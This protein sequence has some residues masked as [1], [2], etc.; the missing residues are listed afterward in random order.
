M[1]NRLALIDEPARVMTSGRPAP[2]NSQG[3]EL[4]RAIEPRAQV[5][6]RT[7][8]V[9]LHGGQ[10]YFYEVV[11]PNSSSDFNARF[12]YSPSSTTDIID[13]KLLL[14]AYVEFTFDVAPR[15]GIDDA[16]RQLPLASVMRNLRLTLNGT[17]VDTTPAEHV[18]AFMK[19]GNNILIRNRDLST[20]AAMPDAFQEYSDKDLL[21]PAGSGGSA[22]SPL[23][24]YGEVGQELSRGGVVGEEVSPTVWRFVITEPLFISPLQAYGHDQYGLTNLNKL[25][26]N[27]DWDDLSRMW[28][29]STGHAALTTCQASFYQQTE[30]LVTQI[31]KNALY[32]T[33][34]EVHYHYLE[35]QSHIREV[36]NLAPNVERVAFSDSIKLAQ[37]PH[38]LMI[39]AK[40]SRNTHNFTTTDTF[41]AIRALKVYWNGRVVM[42]TATPQQLYK[43][44]VK[45]GYNDNY[46]GFSKFTGSPILLNIATDIG[47]PD[48]ESPGTRTQ[49][50]LRI[51]ATLVNT[52]SAAVDYEFYMIPVMQGLISISENGMINTLGNISKEDNL[53]VVNIPQIEYQELLMLEGGNIF[54]SIKHFLNKGARSVSHVAG[55]V[56][57]I[58]DVIAKETGGGVSG[59]GVSGG[60]VRASAMTRG[61]LR[62]R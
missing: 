1:S 17:G 20:T 9:M 4:R 22:R 52:S 44:S 6:D 47:L 27:I 25:L 34:P 7:V 53:E 13:R 30:L 61:Q 45:N 8:E 29:H 24:G 18:H 60:G 10:N 62:F 3:S 26:V 59:G 28:S 41:A 5:S 16:L 46:S 31:T 48:T 49:A 56:G 15:I 21:P 11:V 42:S 33:F 55:S 36:N 35:P 50:T 54:S 12:D 2:L 39:Y 32:P 58:A 19:Y 14:R 37:V 40:R 57:R 51:E 23:S 38:N 43:V